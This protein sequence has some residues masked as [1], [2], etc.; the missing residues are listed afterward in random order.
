LELVAVTPQAGISTTLCNPALLIRAPSASAGVGHR[1]LALPARKSG[2][3][4]GPLDSHHLKDQLK[5]QRKNGAD[6]GRE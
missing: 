5:E 4:S 6:D 2:A 1:S 3:W